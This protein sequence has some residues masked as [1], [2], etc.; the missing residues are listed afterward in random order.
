MEKCIICGCIKDG[1]EYIENI[2]KNIEKI[3]H[4]LMKQK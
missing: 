2:F 3:H 1:A 4:Y